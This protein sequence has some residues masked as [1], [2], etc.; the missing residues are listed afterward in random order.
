MLEGNAQDHFRQILALT[1]ESAGSKPEPLPA[2]IYK[3]VKIILENSPFPDNMTKKEVKQVEQIH[4]LL[5]A[6]LAGEDDAGVIVNQVLLDDSITLLSHCLGGKNMKALKFVCNDLKLLPIDVTF[7][8]GILFPIPDITR[9]TG[10][11]AS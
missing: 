5:M 3:F 9:K 11:I 8:H 4:L 7:N 10:F 1:K 2:F 6:P